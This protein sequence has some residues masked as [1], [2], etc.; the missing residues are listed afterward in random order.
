M[1][2]KSKDVI[3]T[4]LQQKLE[5]AMKS[6][7]AAA[8]TNVFADFASDLQQDILDDFK[9]YQK[10]NNTSILAKRG[11][12]QLTT[13]ERNFYDSWIK[14][15]KS[16]N[17][18]MAFTGLDNTTLPM[19][20]LDTV[21]DDIK[22]TFPILSAINFVNTSTITRMIVNKQGMQLATWGALNTAIAT[23]LSGAI[24]TIDVGTKKLTAFMA[25]SRDMLDAGPE[26]MDA[27]VR[28]VLGEA[29]GYGL[30][31]GIVAGTGKDQP[32]GMLKDINGAVTDGVY[33]DKATIAVTSLDAKTIGEIAATLA[34]GPNG[35]QRAVPQILVVTSPAD[36]FNKI[37]PA[38]TYMTPNGTYVNDVLPYPSKIVQDINVP[39]GKAI[40]G[41]ASR[42]F[43][44]VGKGGSGGQIEYSD[45]FRFLDDERTYKIKLYG[46]G[47]PLDGNAFVVADISGLQ[48]L[49][50][51][52]NVGTVDGTV[53]TKTVA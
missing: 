23:E 14:A 44:G 18:K 30:A 45:E 49:A 28:A 35:R 12:R 43:M 3:K 21:L 40:F 37:M 17:P 53:T 26:W 39:S 34:S 29:L 48:P 42:Y 24:G 7:D 52:V 8:V 50:L 31:K 6:T 13:D 19:T 15:A 47:Q 38:T 33:P 22:S 10:T 9:T 51:K 46:N 1:T 41:L 27:Y 36:Y 20:I 4:E 11:I 5:A 25:I 32:I 2:M 16:D